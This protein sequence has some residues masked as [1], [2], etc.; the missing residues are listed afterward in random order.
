MIEV[1]ADISCPFAYV[2]LH[3]LASRRTLLGKDVRIRTRAWPLELVNDGPTDPGKIAD[4]VAALQAQVDSSLFAGF[5]A[6]RLPSTTLPAL[7]LAA[8]AY[9]HSDE[10]GEQVS[11]ALR[12]ALFLDGGDVSDAAVLGDI[13]TEFGLGSPGP[14]Q[15]DDVLQDWTDGQTRDVEGSPHFFCADR[16]VFSPGLSIS[17]SNGEISV[18]PT[19]DALDAFIA[20]CTREH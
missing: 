7:D 5:D 15:R 6:Q 16:N 17:N 4:E 11:L 8:L 10:V 12:K 20:A 3:Q 18:T 2:Q 19:I 9:R 1:F 13:A 14:S